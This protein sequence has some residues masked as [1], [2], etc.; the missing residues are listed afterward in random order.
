MPTT[1]TEPT[2]TPAQ[3]STRFSDGTDR[4]GACSLTVLRPDPETML[5]SVIGELD[6]AVTERL[7]DLLKHRLKSCLRTVV[8]DLS[9]VS[10]CNTAGLELIREC[11]YRADAY[12]TTLQV[13][14]H[15]PGPITRVFHLAD[16]TLLDIVTN[17]DHPAVTAPTSR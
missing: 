13:V 12:D 8:L 6:L 9:L 1:N 16:P 2:N 10:F 7:R 15:T 17:P 3:S 4:R 14:A 11:R 5:I